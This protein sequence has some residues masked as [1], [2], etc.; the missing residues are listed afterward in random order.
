MT[1]EHAGNRVAFETVGEAV[2]VRDASEDDEVSL[3]LDR[4]PSL[5][6]ALTDLFPFP[7][8]GAVSFETGRIE[9]PSYA[10]IRIR[11]ADGD[12]IATL[13][14]ADEFPR[15]TYYVELTAAFKLYLRVDDAALSTTGMIDGGAVELSF[16]EPTTVS[17]GARSAHTRPEATVTVPDDPE[18]MMDAVSVLGTSIKEFSPERSWPTLRGYPPRI[19][20]GDELRIPDYLEPPDTGIELTVPPTFANV[21][22]VAPLAF[23]LGATVE[24]GA[25]PALRLDNGYVER[26]PRE[27]EALER[28]IERLLGRTLLLDSLVRTEGYVPS[29]RFE[30]EQL[31]PQLPFY[32]PNLYDCTVSMQVMEYLEVDWS[33]LEPYVP[34][35]PIRATL[36]PAPEDVELLSHLAHALGPVRVDEGVPAEATDRDAP[37]AESPWLPTGEPRPTSTSPGVAT[38]DPAGYENALDRTKSQQGEATVVFLTDTDRRAERIREAFDSPTLPDGIGAWTVESRPDRQTVRRAV[39]DPD[40]D[41]LYSALP[42]ARDTIACRDGALSLRDIDQI[43]PAMVAFE[44]THSPDDARSI[45]ERGG[46]AAT[47]L[48]DPIEADRL[49]T[50]VGTLARGTPIAA[51]VAL[52]GVPDSTDVRFVGDPS[53][54]LVSSQGRSIRVME[55]RSRSEARHDARTRSILTSRIRRGTESEG[56]KRWSDN[57]A[58]LLGTERTADRPLTTTEVLDY[59]TEPDSLVRLNGEIVFESDGLTAADVERSARRATESPEVPSVEE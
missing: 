29:D 1:G 2:S 53:I 33:T 23:Y 6:P 36:R 19:E 20:R 13:R 35:T 52:A 31:G 9:I 43:G 38:L 56:L 27:P 18:A 7:V 34:A 21:Y 47:V 50:L 11:G 24:P 45:V 49:R 14:E 16:D 17:V 41:L 37:L 5:S 28:R 8:D 57:N 51:S 32:P 40:I 58:E 48:A 39:T 42:T 54:P 55:I 15:G 22:R 26:L 4:E 12:V 10:G 30:Y 25:D 59:V 3:R 46:L 44:R